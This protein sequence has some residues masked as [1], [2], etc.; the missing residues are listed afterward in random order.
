MVIV[1][2]KGWLYDTI[3]ARAKDLGIEDRVIF[4]GFVSDEALPILY[5]K[6]QCFCLVSLYE[7]FGFPVLEAMQAETPVVASN[8]SSLP[9]LVGK[10]GILVNPEDTQE[11]AHAIID[12]LKMTDPDRRK[13]SEIGKKQAG[14]FTWEKTAKE[15]LEILE[16]VGNKNK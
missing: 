6:A 16:E 11:I 10:A 3:L 9:E 13:L 5:N 14:K 4:T 1:G 15:T 12:I 7:G 8:V 2:K